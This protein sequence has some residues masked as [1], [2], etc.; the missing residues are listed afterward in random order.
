M[1][2]EMRNFEI[3]SQAASLDLVAK[4]NTTVPLTTASMQ[5]Y[6]A[7]HASNYDTICV[8]VAVIAPSQLT[9]FNAAQSQGM[10]VANLAKKFSADPSGRKGGAYGCFGP[11]S[12]SY[13][14]VRSDTL[15]T[16][17]NTFPTTP[18]QISYNNTTAD[19]FVAPTSR[20][21]TP[22]AQAES[23]VLSDLENANASAANTEKSNI[24]YYST[25]AIDPSFG[26]WG[27]GTS[28]PNVFAPALPS[29]SAVGST[30]ITALG[31]GASTYK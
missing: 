16:A 15:S 26:R 18:Q 8:S 7:T 12:S 22:F 5:Q 13:S 27:L 11:S 29:S 3:A 6:F 9:A 23:A 19:L 21:A 31:A 2:V 17:L 1:P 14:G 20:A 10:S 28:G 30:T 24:L 25:V 4:L